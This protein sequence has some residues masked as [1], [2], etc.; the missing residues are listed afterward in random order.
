MTL[1]DICLLILIAFAMWAANT[2]IPMQKALR[3][4]VNG[5]VVLLVLLW[6]FL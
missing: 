5:V 6:V 4:I 2:Y 1:L 3:I